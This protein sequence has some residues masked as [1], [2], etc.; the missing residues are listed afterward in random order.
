MKHLASLLSGFVFAVG[1]A[2]AGMTRPEK[3]I[4]FLDFR[5]PWDPAL[6]FVMG[7]GVLIYAV[8]WRLRLRRAA[9]L[10]APA[11][12]ELKSAPIDRRLLLGAALFGVGWALAGVCPGPGIAALPVGG[13]AAVMFVVAMAA[14][15]LLVS[16]LDHPRAREATGRTGAAA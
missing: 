7:G 2:L 5:G 4:G 10:R 15:W 3:V 1:L 12:P 11:F 8:A 9:P 13:P 16:R 14:G 6:V